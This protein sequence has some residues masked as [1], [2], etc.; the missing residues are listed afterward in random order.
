MAAIFDWMYGIKGKSPRTEKRCPWLP[1]VNMG[2]S[3]IVP[4][5]K[6]LEVLYH[7]ELVEIRRKLYQKE[8]ERH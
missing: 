4:A 1:A 7:P 8:M 6:V 5:K 2:V 3:I